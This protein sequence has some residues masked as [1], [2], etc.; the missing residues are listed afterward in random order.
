M[1]GINSEENQSGTFYPV[2]STGPAQSG[3]PVVSNYCP[4]T[5]TGQEASWPAGLNLNLRRW[6]EFQVPPTGT[7]GTGSGTAPTTSD[8]CHL[9]PNGGFG[10]GTCLVEAL[11]NAGAVLLPYSY[12]GATLSKSSS[13]VQF[14]FTKYTAG[15]THLPPKLS[16][17]MLNQEIASIHNVWPAT[18][19][20]VVGHSYGGM[21]AEQWWEQA[22]AQP[23]DQLGVTHVFSLDSPINGHVNCGALGLLPSIGTFVSQDWCFRWDHAAALDK[24]IIAADKNTLLLFTAI[25][26]PLDT[27]YPFP[28]STLA[29]Q[30]VWSCSDT[31]S[32]A[33][34]QQLTDNSSCTSAHWPV[35]YVS[36]SPRCAAT[37]GDIY[38]TTGHDIVKACPAVIKLIV[39]AVL[40]A[41]DLATSQATPVAGTA[42]PADPCPTSYGVP[43]QHHPT[44]PNTIRT[45]LDRSVVGNLAFYA[46]GAVTVL[47]PQGWTCMA[48]VGADGTASM[49]VKPKGSGHTEDVYAQLAASCIGCIAE[50]ACPVFR[51][52]TYPGLPCIVHSPAREIHNRL[53]QTTVSFE[54]PPPL[55]ASARFLGA[56]IQQMASSSISRIALTAGGDLSR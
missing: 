19:I 35:T 49:T 48:V 34:I 43:D 13:G 55:R 10:K 11:A 16:I 40:D 26:T 3:V 36:N 6:S 15:S 17:S 29:S 37:G 7:S 8:A 9:P 28:W 1:D 14:S 53:N 18:R 23:N 54:D 2:K 47:A 39:Q 31:P 33:A 24:L 45:A 46:N 56:H 51:A 25:G 30:I 44:A 50:I 52:A 5:A 4:L 20:V 42:I 41:R 32:L 38:G 21:V 12:A 27:T 22:R